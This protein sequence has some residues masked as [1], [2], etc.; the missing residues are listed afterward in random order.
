MPDRVWNFDACYRLL[1]PLGEAL[2]QYMLTNGNLHVGDTPVPVLLP[3]NKKIKTGRLWTYVRDDHNAGSMN[4][5]PSR[6]KC[7]GTGRRESTKVNPVTKRVG[8]LAAGKMKTL[9]R[10]LRTGEGTRRLAD[11]PGPWATAVAYN[12]ANSVLRQYS[13][14][15]YVYGY[16]VPDISGECPATLSANFKVNGVQHHS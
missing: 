8:K 12:T 14:L 4:C 7:G 6:W 5:T 11:K 15:L 10:P 16:L 9:S 1:F 2:Q 3:G 13:L